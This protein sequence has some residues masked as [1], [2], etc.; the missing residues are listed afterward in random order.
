MSH[1]SPVKPSYGVYIVICTLDW[2]SASV[3]TVQYIFEKCAIISLDN[4][5]LP[6]GF[7]AII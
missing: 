6:A 1:S 2:S 7:Q 3:T 4:G 5:L